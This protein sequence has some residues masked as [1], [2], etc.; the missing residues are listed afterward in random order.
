MRP[1]PRPGPGSG[2]PAPPL[3]TSIA[4][5][6][7][8]LDAIVDHAIA[9]G[10][11]LGYFAALYRRVTRKVA[12]GIEAG[13]FQDGPRMA[14][15]DVVFANRYLAAYHA[16]RRGEAVTGSW[17]AAFA[18]EP[19]S[20]L[21]ALQ[22]L[23]LGMNAHINLDLGIAAH[24]L[25]CGA[26]M[27]LR[28]DFMLIN[29]ILGREIDATQDR[30]AGFV[31]HL[32]LVDR[33]LGSVD[34]QLSMFSISYARDKA[35]TQTLELCASEADMHPALIQRRDE[36]VADF[37]QKLIRPRGFLVR[38]CVVLLRMFERGSTADKLRLL[39]AD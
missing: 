11:P 3:P 36:A 5:V 22:H 27:A 15:L 34:E 14:E 18:V 8:A 10:S 21:A 9:A 38:A 19:R 29:E 25:A 12:L 37:A 30:I 32:G 33:L 4:E 7:S 6:I 13:L 1:D 35:W 26:P 17:R 39:A 24:E 31:R 28:A 20:D 23:L 16:H 2:D